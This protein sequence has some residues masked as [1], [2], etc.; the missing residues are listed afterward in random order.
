MAF[1][2]LGNALDPRICKNTRLNKENNNHNHRGAPR[3]CGARPKAAPMLSVLNLMT[4]CL[5]VDSVEDLL[6]LGLLGQILPI[7]R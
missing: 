2:V 5:D 6:I 7:I 3:P 4:L 1:F